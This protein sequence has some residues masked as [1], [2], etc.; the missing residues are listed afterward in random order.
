MSGFF[1]IL[2]LIVTIGVI[3]VNGWTDA[4]S[5]IGT[6]VST[7]SMK[8]NSA[9]RLAAVCNLLGLLAMSLISASVTETMLS[10]TK[11]GS[12]SPNRSIAAL[13]AAMFSIILF[14]VAAW[15]FG[16][17]TSESHAL[18]AALAGA[19]VASG[20]MMDADFNAWGK[21]LWGLAIS[22]GMGIAVSFILTKLFAPLISKCSIRALDGMQIFSAG[23]SA[24]LHGAQ[25]G[26]K[27]VA[28]LVI[29]DQLCSGK[30]NGGVVNLW[31]HKLS[32]VL[33]AVVMALGT[34]V[35]G[36]RIIVT[37]GKK[38]TALNK[39]QG[40][41]ADIAGGICLAAASLYGIP[42]STTH[43]KTSAIIGASI[44]QKEGKTNFSILGSMLS[45]WVVT[46][47]ICFLLGFLLSRLFFTVGRL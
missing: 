42:V 21:V 26:Q 20:S 4:P 8:Y 46:F 38:M 29:V 45:A 43:T 39:P 37:V 25:D 35:G 28:V 44:A 33:C 41:I 16:I 40:V 27:F 2:L 34:A 31:E 11:L 12:A 23:V 10:I 1:Q 22:I 47:P 6:V 15:W 9:V 30:G 32:L 3:F 14:A 19:G 5:A 7:G 18:I 13:S 24:F 36:K 17:P